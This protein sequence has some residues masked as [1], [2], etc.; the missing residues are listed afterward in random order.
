MTM[1]S[2]G[3]RLTVTLVDQGGN[4]S[5]Q[6]FPLTG[7]DFA[8]AVAQST[9]IRSALAAITGLV[10]A[11]YSVADVYEEDDTVFGT[12][13]AENVALIS[14]RIDDTS[15]KYATIKI[16]GPVDGIFQDTAGPL[17]NVVDPSDADLQTY[18][19]VF[20][21]GAQALVSDGEALLDV[22]TAGNVTGKRIHR[23]SRKG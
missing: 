7:G 15:L 9:T 3:F 5:I 12:A 6:R 1:Q 11:G 17:Y 10:E 19:A 21:T 8:T 18:L 14:A 22:S 20:E 2:Q 4:K 16:P 23:K 13:E